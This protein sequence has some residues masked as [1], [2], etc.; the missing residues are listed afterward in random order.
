[1]MAPIF[2]ICSGS[3]EVRALLGSEPVRLYPFGLH[4]DTVI[5]PYA[6]WQNI[7]GDPENYLN[8]RPDADRYSLQVDI[9]ADTAAGCVAVARALRD[10]IEP[11]AYITR[12]GGQ[13][14]DAT[15]KRYRYSFDV[16]WI[17]RR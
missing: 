6:V 14:R 9:Y 5:Y 17:V 3:D 11:H 8:Q 12:W 1:M 10:A 2:A 4:D 7:S 16:D 13:T 15:T